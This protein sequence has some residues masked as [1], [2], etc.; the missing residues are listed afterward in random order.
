MLVVFFPNRFLRFGDGRLGNF[1]ALAGMGLLLCGIMLRISSRGYKSE[2]SSGGIFLVQGGPYTLV[3]NPMYLGILF[4]GSG[5][6]LASFKWWVLLIFLIVLG[7]RYLTLVFKEEKILSSAFGKEYADYCARTPR[8][9]PRITSLFNKDVSSYLPLKLKWVKK[10]I[11]SIIPVILA[12]LAL[13]Y[14]AKGKSGN[15][16]I[17]A[18]QIAGM[19][20]MVVFFIVITVAL[21]KKNED[22]AA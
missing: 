5:F 20:A 16:A 4:I 10:E 19:A 21:S 2:H 11:N 9:F 14:W 7:A 15:N 1:F 22:P 13:R 12:V 17:F 8:L 3:R 18:L 6:I